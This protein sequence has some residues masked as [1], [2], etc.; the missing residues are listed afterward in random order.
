[1]TKARARLLAL[2]AFAAV[3]GV[4]VVGFAGIGEA[5][6]ALTGDLAWRQA[7]CMGV[8]FGLVLG[9]VAAASLAVGFRQSFVLLVLPTGLIAVMLGLTLAAAI[10][11]PAHP[12]L[13]A[14]LAALLAAMLAVMWAFHRLLPEPNPGQLVA[15]ADKTERNA[16]AIARTNGAM[17]LIMSLVI[18]LVGLGAEDI[19]W[20]GRLGMA[21]VGIVTA[22]VSVKWTLWGWRKPPPGP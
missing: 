15:L 1:M 17:L 10:Q 4:Q 22:I 12:L 6:G 18:V 8:L 5:M 21:A 11:K 19:P 20:W 9:F 16:R 14:L 3:A 2:A 7:R 13:Y